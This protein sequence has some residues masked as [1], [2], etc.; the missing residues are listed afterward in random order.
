MRCTF[1]TLSVRPK[2]F[3]ALT[4]MDVGELRSFVERLHPAWE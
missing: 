3:R 2:I 4:T 1:E